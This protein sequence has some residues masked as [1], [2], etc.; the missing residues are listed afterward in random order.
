LETDLVAV[1]EGPAFT[2]PAFFIF[3]FIDWLVSL[4]E[5][6]HLLVLLK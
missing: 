1:L 4:L 6:I 5:Q 2:V 3:L